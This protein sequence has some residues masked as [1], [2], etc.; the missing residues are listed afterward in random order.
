MKKSIQPQ[1]VVFTLLL[2]LFAGC[3]NKS[4]NKVDAKDDKSNAKISNVAAPG[5]TNAGASD[6]DAKQEDEKDDKDADG[7]KSTWSKVKNLYSKAKKKGKTT[8]SD[9]KQWVSGLLG[10]ASDSTNKASRDATEWAQGLYQQALD[11]G[12]TQA[13]NVKDWVMEDISKGSAWQYKVVKVE[14]NPEK[15]MNELG[16]KRWECFDVEA[17]YMYFKRK[18]KSYLNKVPVKD[19]MRLLPLIGSGDSGE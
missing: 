10:S 8:A 15:K 12:E 19:L 1:L 14:G 18:P 4:D 7:S 16:A 2:V 9:A 13:T 5:L 6:Q 11:Q 3:Q 17:G